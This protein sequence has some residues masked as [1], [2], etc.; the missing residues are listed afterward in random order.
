M[1][2]LLSVLT[3]SRISKTLQ[4]SVRHIFRRQCTGSEVDLI[5][6]IDYAG[7]V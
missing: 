3:V 4:Q 6:F 1:T 2:Y 5:R 7:V